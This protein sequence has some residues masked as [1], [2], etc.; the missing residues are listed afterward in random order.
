MPVAGAVSDTAG[1]AFADV[2]C[3]VAAG[4]VVCAPSASYA[5]AV[6]V[7][8]PAATDDHVAVYGEVVAV[9]SLVAP[10]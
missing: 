2:T 5:I 7:Y 8:V 3:T 10:E 6:T 1:A 9:A 4:E